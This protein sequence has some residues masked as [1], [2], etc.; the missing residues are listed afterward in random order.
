MEEEKLPKVLIGVTTYKGKEYI[1]DRFVANLQRL[2]YPKHLIE[3]LFVD[4][5]P[6]LNY[7]NKIRRRLPRGWKVVHID[8][9][10]NSRVALTRSQ[11]Y[12]RKYMLDRDHDYLLFV[13]SDL[14]PDPQALKRLLAHKKPVVGSTYIIGTGDIRLPCIFMGGAIV[15]GV[16]GTR[17][18]GTHPDP[19][20]GKK[21]LDLDEVNAFLNTGLRKCHGCGFGTTLIRRDILERFPFWTDKRLSDKHSDVYWYMDLEQAGVQA[22]IDTDHIIYHEPIPWEQ[23]KDR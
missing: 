16:P 12:I 10:E 6:G 5:S 15:K 3:V 21:R 7:T 17:Q 13:E 9:G 14:L 18:L 19:I 8:R 11:N 20:T 1:F 22:Y 2:D 23:V 4:N